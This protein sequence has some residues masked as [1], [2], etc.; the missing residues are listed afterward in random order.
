MT[1]IRDA[2]K[3]WRQFEQH[4]RAG[5]WHWVPVNDVVIGRVCDAFERAASGCIS[6]FGG[7]ASPDVRR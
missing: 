5:L 2:H 1:S 7:R 4:E 3:I 6:A